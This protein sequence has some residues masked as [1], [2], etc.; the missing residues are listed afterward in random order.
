MC[1]TDEVE[2]CFDR[3]DTEIYRD[4]YEIDIIMAN[5][6]TEDEDDIPIGDGSY[7]VLLPGAMPG[8]KAIRVEDQPS[9]VEE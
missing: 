9:F 3:P 1:L 5:A 2:G 6:G 7:L 8:W 4:L